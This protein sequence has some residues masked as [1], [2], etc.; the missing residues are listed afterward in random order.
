MTFEESLLKGVQEMLIKAMSEYSYYNSPLRK[1]IEMVMEKYS[2]KF[3]EI[4]EKQLKESLDDETFKMEVKKAIAQKVARTLI[5]E[6]ESCIA[7][8]VQKLKQDVTFR[9]RLTIA[10]DNLLKEYEK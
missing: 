1:P 7:R 5:N 8:T 4:F 6:S 10:I 3:A 2:S 9:A